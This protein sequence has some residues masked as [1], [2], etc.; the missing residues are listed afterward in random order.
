[1]SGDLEVRSRREFRIGAE[2]A[3]AGK[4]RCQK[5]VGIFLTVSTLRSETGIHFSDSGG[6][7]WI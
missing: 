6:R 3:I 2:E 5:F 1:M 4:E 7:G